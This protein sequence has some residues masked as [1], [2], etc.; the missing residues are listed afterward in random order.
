M[1]R[2]KQQGQPKQRSTKQPSLSFQ[3]SLV[4][5]HAH[6]VPVLPAPYASTTRSRA[7][8]GDTTRSTSQRRRQNPYDDPYDGYG[9]S[10]YD[11][12]PA[13]VDLSERETSRTP[14][15]DYHDTPADGSPSASVSMRAPVPAD[16]SMALTRAQTRQMAAPATGAQERA[17]VVG[18]GEEGTALFIPGANKHVVAGHIMAPRRQARPVLLQFVV[19]MFTMMAIFS[20]LAIATPL[21]HTEA[22]AGTFSSSAAAVPWIPTPTPTPRPT[23]T[24]SVYVPHYANPGTQAIVNEIVAVF[25]PYANGALAV[26]K[27]ESGY[28]PNAYNPYPIAGSHASGVFQ[29]LYPSTWDT[30]GYASSSPYDWNANIHAAYQLFSRDGYTWSEWQCQP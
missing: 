11:S 21:G 3:E 14:A 27:C 22:F 23:P 18:H 7:T 9:G 19:S 13:E 2:Q 16:E 24:P 28:D 17:L 8:L 1:A 29:I 10:R 26:A 4:E 5:T 25:G 15:Q 30:T 20:G 12:K 6:S